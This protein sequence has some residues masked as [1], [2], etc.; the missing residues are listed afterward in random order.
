MAFLKRRKTE[1][2]VRQWKE[3]QECRPQESLLG[4]LERRK[5]W[6]KGRRKA[7]DK[8]E[9]QEAPKAVVARMLS[10]RAMT[11][12]FLKDKRGWVDSDMCWRCSKGRQNRVYPFKECLTWKKETRA[13]WDEVG[14]ILGKI[15]RAH[16]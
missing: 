3:Q 13:L 4:S 11:T 2:A 5:D 1:K 12:T 7:K 16:V 15:G 14:D 6:L 9:M 8:K 10:G